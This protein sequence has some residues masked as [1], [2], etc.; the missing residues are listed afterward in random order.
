M[1]DILP[2]A[3]NK[4]ITGTGSHNAGEVFKIDEK[5]ADFLIKRGA[6]KPANQKPGPVKPDSP[7]KKEVVAAAEKAQA[8]ADSGKPADGGKA[9]PAAKGK[10]GR[11]K[12]K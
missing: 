6:A 4:V 11:K 7:E 1:A 2:V 10:R 12:A 9:K 3:I 8:A 5:D